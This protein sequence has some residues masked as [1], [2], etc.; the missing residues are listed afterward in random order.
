MLHVVFLR[1][2]SDGD[3][4]AVSAQSLELEAIG[5]SFH[6]FLFAHSF[7]RQTKYSSPPS[8]AEIMHSLGISNRFDDHEQAAVFRRFQRMYV[9][10]IESGRDLGVRVLQYSLKSSFYRSP[11]DRLAP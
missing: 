5:E 11:M 7:S 10:S 1:L 9:H 6:Y 3:T 4:S 8:Y 2:K